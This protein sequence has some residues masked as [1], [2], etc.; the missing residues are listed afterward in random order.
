MAFA[1]N[2]FFIHALGDAIS[3]SILGW[4]SDHWG[5][6]NSL[7]VT[8]FVMALAGLFCFI[9]GSYIKQDMADAEGEEQR[10]L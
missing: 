1:V 7:L 8:P 5:L 4:L 6:R 10:G 2:I 3:P 9:C